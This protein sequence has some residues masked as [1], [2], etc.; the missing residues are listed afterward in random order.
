MTLHSHQNSLPSTHHVRQRD[1]VLAACAGGL[2]TSLTMTPLD[3][4]KTRVQTQVSLIHPR[5]F[6]PKRSI[7][8]LQTNSPNHSPLNPILNE[9]ISPRFD[10]RA[11]K[12][13]CASLSL[14][15]ASPPAANPS[16]CLTTASFQSLQP[17]PLPQQLI[18]SLHPSPRP[19]G[20]IDSILN[21]VRYEGLGTL[22]RG[23]GPAL[24]MSIPA[25]AVY[26]VGYDRLRASLLEL[27]P[28]ADRS[29][30]WSRT[31]LAPLL[32]GA[33]ARSSVAILFCPLELI[34]TRL[35]SAPA[36]SAMP[37]TQFNH[38]SSLSTLAPTSSRLIIRD[39]LRSVQHAGLSSLYRGL[40]A[41]LWR[42]VPFSAIYWSFYEISRKTITNGCGFG[43]SQHLSPTRLA[44]QSFLAGALSGC[45]AAV[46]TNPFDVVKT[47]RQASGEGRRQDAGTLRMIFGIAKE[48]GRQGLMKGLSPRLAKIIPSC[49]IMIA[50]YEG[51]AQVFARF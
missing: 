46:V 20:I 13:S 36:V 44:S 11:L 6:S 23:L 5:S 17:H 33:L 37:L 9:P 15:L 1:K 27:G 49:G 22:W 25:Q 43:E 29:T 32:A 50:S 47:R 8:H 12:H 16:C 38:N 51:L 10:H 4:I 48:E 42:D 41:M 26:M 18:H 45:V 40:P 7:I 19:S 2:L 28:T 39:T 35:Q 14:C 3:V 21:I 30:T 34:R 31:T 24:V